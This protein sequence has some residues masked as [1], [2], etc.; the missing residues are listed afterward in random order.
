MSHDPFEADG[1]LRDLAVRL[2]NEDWPPQ[3]N[4][5]AIGVD[6]WVRAAPARD[7]R[8]RLVGALAEIVAPPPVDLDVLPQGD[9]G[10]GTSFEDLAARSGSQLTRTR[11]CSSIYWVNRSSKVLA[12]DVPSGQHGRMV[13]TVRV[14]KAARDAAV[15]QAVLGSEGVVRLTANQRRSL[16]EVTDRAKRDAAASGTKA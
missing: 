5:L 16:A 13:K 14:G 6:G 10:P 7:A 15:K 8:G 2:M 12:T 4:A 3:G 9:D 11:A 1:S